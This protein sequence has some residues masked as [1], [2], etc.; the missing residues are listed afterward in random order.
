MSFESAK[1]EIKSR[2]A[3]EGWQKRIEGKVI[4]IRVALN[5]LTNENIA[6]YFVRKYVVKVPKIRANRY[7]YIK[8]VPY[9]ARIGKRLYIGCVPYLCDLQ[10]G[11]SYELY[12]SMRDAFMKE[13]LT[14]DKK[15]VAIS[16]PKAR[17]LLAS[18]KCYPRIVNFAK[19]NIIKQLLPAS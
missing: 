16:E 5:P 2:I 19:G 12:L 7:V 8:F 4:L 10:F 13:A 17:R 18:G 9:K 11:Y 15:I 6:K 3:R 1:E 14:F